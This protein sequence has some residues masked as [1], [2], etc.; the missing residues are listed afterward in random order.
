MRKQLFHFM[1]GSLLILCDRVL[2][3]PENRAF[4]IILCFTFKCIVTRPRG[5]YL[6]GTHLVLNLSAHSHICLSDWW[7]DRWL[8]FLKQVNFSIFV[9]GEALRR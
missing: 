7:V 4:F 2:N 8:L 1:S 3:W 9:D 5:F 6:N